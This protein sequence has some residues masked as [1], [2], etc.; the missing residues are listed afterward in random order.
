ME[1]IL[2]IGHRAV[3]CHGAW[4][5]CPWLESNCIKG[6]AFEMLPTAYYLAVYLFCWNFT[7]REVHALDYYMAAVYE[8]HAILNPNATAL[9]DRRSALEFMSKNLDIYEAQVTVAAKKGAQIIVFPEDGIHGFNYTRQSIY[10][11][12]D[13]IPPSHLLPWNPCLEPSKFLDTEVL[14]RLSCMATKGRMFLVANLG[15]K[16]SCKPLKAQCPSD[17]RFQFNTNVVF[18]DNGTLIATYFKQNLYFEF[19]FDTPP[20]VQHVVFDTPFASKFATFTCFDILFFEPAVSLIEKYNVKHV[21]YP[22]AWMNQLPLLSAIQIQRG[23]ASA[24]NINFITANIHHTTLGMTGSGIFSPSHSSYH[25][26][27]TNENGTLILA[28]LPVNPSED[29]I[30]GPKDQIWP[31]NSEVVYSNTLTK[32]Q[33]CETEETEETCGRDVNTDQIPHPVFYSEMMYDNFTFVPL[34]ENKGMLDVCAGTLCCSLKYKKTILSDELYALGVYDGL[35]TVHGTYS[36]QICALVKCGGL[37]PSTCGHEVTNADSVINLQL[38]GNF[39][40]KHIFPLLL[41]S[42]V[43]VQLP[44]FSG[45]KGNTFYMNANNMSSSLLTAALYGRYYERD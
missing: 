37:E 32:H 6:K 17:G 43:T 25:Y 41:T 13:Q 19:G 39:S 21:V 44:D 10:P 3:G 24:F 29:V 12:L 38:W 7:S 22:T 40:T 18:N 31:E 33:V 11:Y 27:M 8:H 16:M 30:V 36:L 5:Q 42:G 14:Q 9:S 15:T 28:K 45:W 1:L 20:E 26:D 34:L 4:L 2:P 23:F 35:H